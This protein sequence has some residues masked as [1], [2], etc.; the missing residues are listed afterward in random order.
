MGRNHPIFCNRFF[1]I[2]TNKRGRYP[3]QFHV[4]CIPKDKKPSKQKNGIKN[5]Y[6]PFSLDDLKADDERMKEEFLPPRVAVLLP[7][8]FSPENSGAWSTLPGGE[9]IWQLR[10]MANKAKAISLYYK[11]SISDRKQ[12]IHI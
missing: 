4:S 2:R 12:A 6:I 8:S 7:A 9:R 11:N 10:I 1:F 3:A 5:I